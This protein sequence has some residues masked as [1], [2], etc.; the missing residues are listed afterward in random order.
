MSRIAEA[1]VFADL[2]LLDMFDEYVRHPKAFTEEEVGTLI[3]AAYGCGYVAAHSDAEPL[4]II[5]ACSYAAT[6]RLTL[7]LS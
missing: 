2:G 6:L 4:P 1:E 3:R 5:D 7:P